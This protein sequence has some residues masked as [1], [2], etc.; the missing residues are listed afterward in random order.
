MSA[1]IDPLDLSRRDGLPDALRV[2]LEDLPRETWEAHPNFGGMVQFWLQ[3]HLMFRRLLDVLETDL[4]R[5]IDRQVGFE[6]YGGRLSHYGGTLLNEL[7]AHHQIEDQHYFPR[8]VTLDTRLEQGFAL[9]DRDHHAMDGAINGVAD[10][11]NTL[12]RSKGADIA[13]LEVVL[14]D[15]ARMLDRHLTDEEEIIVPVILK[16]G[17]D[18]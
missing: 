8:L 10:G 13:A 15:M 14:R 18:G 11:A 16:T 9:L 17:F 7:H 1:E 5:L 12:L 6:T 2:L 4:Q 3:R